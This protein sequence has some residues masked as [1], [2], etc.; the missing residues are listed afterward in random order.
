[1]VNFTQKSKQESLQQDCSPLSWSDG[2]GCKHNHEDD[3]EDDGVMMES[4]P[5]AGGPWLEPL[6]TCRQRQQQLTR[7]YEARPLGLLNTRGTLCRYREEQTLPRVT[8]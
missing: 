5:A 1:M 3:E 6:T 7:C 8:F 2:D 4:R